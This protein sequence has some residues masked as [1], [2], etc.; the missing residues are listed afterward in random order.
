MLFAQKLKEEK[1]E[2]A[3]ETFFRCM[4]KGKTMIGE[5]KK[6]RG[7]LSNRSVKI[8]QKGTKEAKA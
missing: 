7:L 2:I 4:F 1:K 8:A 6:N 5:E 3:R